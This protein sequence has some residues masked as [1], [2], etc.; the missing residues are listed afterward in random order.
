MQNAGGVVG[1]I[2][3][4]VAFMGREKVEYFLIAEASVKGAAF[5]TTHKKKLEIGN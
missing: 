1:G 5:V 2:G 3:K 4:F